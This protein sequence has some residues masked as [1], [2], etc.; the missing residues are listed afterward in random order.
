MGVENVVVCRTDSEA[1]KLLTSNIDA[2]DHPFILGSTNPALKIALS[3]QMDD[4][5]QKGKFGDE[6]NN[7]EADWIKSAKLQ[8]YP[9]A[10]A[11]AL[12]AKNPSKVGEWWERSHQLRHEDA[13]ELAK[14][15]GADVYWC[16]ETPRTREGYYRVKPCTEYSIARSVAFAPF[17]DMLWMETAKPGRAQAQHFAQGVLKVHPYAKL[18]Y[19]L[20]P[21]FNW[22]AAGMS[23]DEIKTYI[24]DLAKMGYC[25][26]FIT[27]AGFHSDA[28]G[29]D[30][31]A[32]DYAKRG[33]LAYCE[34]IQRKERE[35]KVE[36]L[37]HQAWSG[38]NYVDAIIKTVTG[39]VSS[40]A[41][42]GHGVTEEQFKS[43]L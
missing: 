42:M 39:G 7:L 5:E 3:R 11:A 40:T 19:N 27:L 6:L 25:W 31:F 36:T 12:K 10:V 1:A 28:V 18:C 32:R 24:W 17:A 14:S 29:I 16:W 35:H 33:M 8:T 43:K 9:E 26:Q 38:A 23:D 20:S 13:V 15:L 4:A 30:L 21:S 41:A 22:D 37:A 2:R 34:Q